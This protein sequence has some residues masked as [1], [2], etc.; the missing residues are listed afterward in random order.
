MR[1]RT[2][3]KNEDFPFLASW[4]EE[5]EIHALWSGG[6]FS[7][8]LK[9]EEFEKY[10]EEKEGDARYVLTDGDGCPVG[11][12]AYS[13]NETDN[14]GFA[15]FI[16]VDGKARGKG[17]GAAMLKLLLKQAFEINGVDC[18]RLN[19][20]ARNEAARRCYRKAGFEESGRAS[21]TLEF[22][23]EVWDKFVME[24]GRKKE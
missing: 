10:F 14:S 6:I 9:K 12:C 20:F 5:E 11:F 7:Y 3:R 15:K 4:L 21:G 22:H 23:G 24:A 17:Y 13:L 8:P 16:V 2:Y 19:V 1:L 18:V